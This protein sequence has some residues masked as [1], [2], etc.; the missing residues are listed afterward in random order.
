MSAHVCGCTC[1]RIVLHY[2]PCIS[3]EYSVYTVY[4]V[5]GNTSMLMIDCSCTS[6]IAITLY[7]RTNSAT[8]NSTFCPRRY[9]VEH[10]TLSGPFWVS[11][12]VAER[13]LSRTVIAIHD[14]L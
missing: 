11:S 1:T 8:K 10:N 12:P 2:S 7:K 3:D 13:S 5:N 6:S 4:S 9:G 14:T